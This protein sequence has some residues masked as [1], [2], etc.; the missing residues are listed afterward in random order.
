[1][2][3]WLHDVCFYPGVKSSLYALIIIPVL[4]ALSTVIVVALIVYSVCCKRR[5]E[6]GIAVFNS[7]TN[8]TKEYDTLLCILHCIMRLCIRHQ[9]GK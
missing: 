4:L 3:G 1:M 6:A 9:D 8:G 2:L 7:N 5:E